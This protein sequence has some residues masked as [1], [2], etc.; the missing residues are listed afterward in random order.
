MIGWSI[1]IVWLFMGGLGMGLDKSAE[2]NPGAALFIAILLGPL[3][4][5]WVLGENHREAAEKAKP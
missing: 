3:A 4:L 2:S 5:G 1:V